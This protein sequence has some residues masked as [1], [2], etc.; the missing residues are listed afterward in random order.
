MSKDGLLRRINKLE[1]GLPSSGGPIPVWALELAEARHRERVTGRTGQVLA[2]IIGPREYDPAE[3]ERMARELAATFRDREDA[4]RGR[5]LSPAAQA[6]M[7]TI[8][9]S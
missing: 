5:P 9:A 2:T 7:D 8:L 6:V 1:S 4:E 3:V